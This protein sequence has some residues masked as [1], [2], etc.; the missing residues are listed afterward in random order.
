MFTPDPTKYVVQ[1]VQSKAPAWTISKEEK[2]TN[3][4]KADSHPEPGKYEYQTFIG[5][6]PK[7]TIGQ[8][9][10][11]NGDFSKDHYDTTDPAGSGTEIGKGIHNQKRKKVNSFRVPGPGAYNPMNMFQSISYSIRTKGMQKK[12]KAKQNP[13]PSV[14][15]YDIRRENSF[16]APSHIFDREKRINPDQVRITNT[17][18]PGPQYYLIIAD[19]FGT[20]GPRFTFS[21]T[22]RMKEPIKRAETPGPGKYK[23]KEYIGN[24]GCKLSFFKDNSP[25]CETNNVPGPGSYNVLLC[26]KSTNPSYRIPSSTRPSTAIKSQLSTPG[27]EKYDPRPLTISQRIRNP[28]WEMGKSNREP[29]Y[30]NSLNTPGPGNYMIKND[31]MPSGPRYTMSAKYREKKK[32]QKPDPGKYEIVNAHHYK[33]PKWIIGHEQREELIKQIKKNNYPGPGSYNFKDSITIHQ[34]SFPHDKRYKVVKKT[35]P[36]PGQYRIP[37]R[38]DDLNEYTRA[39]GNFD[40]TFKYV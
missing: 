17:N 33:E 36:G 14:G 2:I 22:N 34:I 3:K 32:E 25:L 38:F 5:E 18:V 15:K 31:L 21:K 29:L 13:N 16:V 20:G 7:Y 27:P 8:K 10:D 30:N 35:Y 19:T 12:N 4:K 39:K 37:C 24:D 9:R 28:K 6:G 11:D 23:F 26:N 40:P 1:P